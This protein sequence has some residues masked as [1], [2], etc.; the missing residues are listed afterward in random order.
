[1]EQQLLIFFNQ[2]T[3]FGFQKTIGATSIVVSE[4]GKV[5]NMQNESEGKELIQF[6]IKTRA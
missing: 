3:F 6:N 5:W 1:M 4:M 2:E